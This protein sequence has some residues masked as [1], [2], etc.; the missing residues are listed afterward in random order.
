MQ[1][2]EWESSSDFDRWPSVVEGSSGGFV[3]FRAL[4]WRW[5]SFAARLERLIALDEYLMEC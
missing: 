4:F 2:D 5:V 1:E 3:A